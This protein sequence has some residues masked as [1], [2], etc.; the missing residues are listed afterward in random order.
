MFDTH[1]TR[2]IGLSCG[3]ETDDML[4]RFDRTMG[5]DGQAALFYSPVD[6]TDASDLH[7]TVVK[8]NA[9]HR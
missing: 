5:R 8:F 4:S 6:F 9:M 1:K 3:E 7:Q 2:V